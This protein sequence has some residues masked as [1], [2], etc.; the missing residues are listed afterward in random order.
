MVFSYLNPSEIEVLAVTRTKF[1]Q[2]ISYQRPYLKYRSENVNWRW[3]MHDPPECDPQ[4]KP[5]GTR[6]PLH[7]PLVQK[8]NR[9]ALDM[10]NFVTLN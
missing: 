9:F 10:D 7:R 1:P 8:P 5:A 4:L 3:N 2:D 6:Q